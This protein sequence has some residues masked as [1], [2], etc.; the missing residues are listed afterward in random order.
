MN[1]LYN[2]KFGQAIG[3][4]QPTKTLKPEVKEEVKVIEKPDKVEVQDTIK[5]VEPP[6]YDAQKYLGDNFANRSTGPV[7]NTSAEQQ[8]K[9]MMQAQNFGNLLALLGDVG[10]LAMGANVDRRKPK[11]LEP[12]MQSIQNRKDQY[13]KD[14]Q[15]FNRQDFEDRMKEGER[16]DTEKKYQDKLGVAAEQQ[17]H[18]RGR[19]ELSD[20]RYDTEWDHMLTKEK[21]ANSRYWAN[22]KNK[23]ES[24][25]EK[26]KLDWYKARTARAKSTTD[27]P[28]MEVNLGGEKKE[29][30]EGDFREYLNLAMA[31][32]D[33][34]YEEKEKAR[35]LE[36]EENG[37]GDDYFKK[38]RKEIDLN[39]AEAKRKVAN[40]IIDMYKDGHTYFR[41]Y[42]D[43]RDN[44]EGDYSIYKKSRVAAYSK[45]NKG[46]FNESL[47]LK[48]GTIFN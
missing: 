12:Y 26:V 20:E 28:F 37:D 39:S 10:G 19:E 40:Y 42:M 35:K 32:D 21:E 43:Q 2:K 45:S 8:D 14:Q 5:V 4:E 6:K 30:S 41:D 27:K 1:P 16:L 23:D 46:K 36:F 17:E 34:L 7:Y 47:N 38:S 29:L 48:R 3:Q 18:K 22:W 25:K 31:E 13:A 9:A 15:V 24:E 44:G 33:R 11:P